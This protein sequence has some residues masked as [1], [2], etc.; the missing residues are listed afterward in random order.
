MEG[1]EL[2]SMEPHQAHHADEGASRGVTI[3]VRPKSHYSATQSQNLLSSV[4]D[5]SWEAFD[6][7]LRDAHADRES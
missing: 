6:P 3:F 7:N 1:Q 5:I 4:A 2:D